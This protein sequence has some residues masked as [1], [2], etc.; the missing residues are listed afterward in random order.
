MKRTAV[1]MA[2]V[3]GPS[4]LT[5]QAT[6]DLQFDHSTVLVS[7]LE[8]SA[9]FYESIL[10]LKALETPWGPTAPIRF[11]SVGGERQLHVG[12]SERDIEPDK[13]AHLAFAVRDFDAYLQFLRGQGI[14]YSNFPGNSSEPQIRPDGVRQ[15]YLQDPDGHWIEINDASHTP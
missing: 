7:D 12:I 11:F 9:T 2:L 6:F 13:N 1:L 15:I 5:A 8:A 14:D 3:V 10:H 4:P